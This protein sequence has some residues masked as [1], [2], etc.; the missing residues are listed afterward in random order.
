[1]TFLCFLTITYLC[2]QS[3]ANYVVHRVI[4]CESDDSEL[5]K[6]RELDVTEALVSLKKIYI[7]VCMLKDGT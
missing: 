1:M 3:S 6:R 4:I 7:Q 5:E 2:W